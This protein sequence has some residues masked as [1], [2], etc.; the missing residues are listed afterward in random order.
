MTIGHLVALSI[1]SLVVIHNVL[2]LL[3]V[4]LYITVLV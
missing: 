4:Y 3:Y 2:I 1:L